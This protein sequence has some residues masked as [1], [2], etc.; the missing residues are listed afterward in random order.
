MALAYTDIALR[1]LLA[2]AIGLLLGGER[3]MRGK[4]VGSRTYVIISISATSIAMISAY[5]FSYDG[6]GYSDPARLMVGI[7]TGIG[8]LCAGVIWRSPEGD[9]QGLTTAADIYAM[10]CLGIA[11]GLGYFFLAAM[12]MAII[13]IAMISDYVYY[14]IKHRRKKE[15]SM[16]SAPKSND[17]VMKQNE[18][19]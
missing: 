17:E 6:T 13:F 19:S 5:G 3:K 1:L 15:E 16:L 7:L 11:V 9:V 14:Q 10:V 2:M 12:A 8:F 18:K 4:P